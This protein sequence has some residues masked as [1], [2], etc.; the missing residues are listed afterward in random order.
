MWGHGAAGVDVE[1]IRPWGCL[2]EGGARTD[3]DRRM[4]VEEQEPP[5]GVGLA[6]KLAVPM[7]TPPH[8]LP[9]PM[10]SHL[11]PSLAARVLGKLW[12]RGV[13]DVLE[14]PSQSPHSLPAFPAPGVLDAAP[15]A[16]GSV[17]GRRVSPTWLGG[18]LGWWRLEGTLMGLE[19]VAP[20]P[21]Q[22]PDWDLLR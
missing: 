9:P 13:G 1:R 17:R 10:S 14:A 4:G 19:A 18:G 6:L 2:A 16:G 21:A 8:P 11:A 12:Y 7:A 15:D 20:P 22:A 3:L 5:F